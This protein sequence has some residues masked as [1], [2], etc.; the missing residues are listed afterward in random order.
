MRSGIFKKKKQV[1]TWLFTKPDSSWRISKASRI[2]VINKSNVWQQSVAV[3]P[4]ERWTLADSYSFF[5]FFIVLDKM[6]RWQ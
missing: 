6:R 4:P 3:L 5:L 2:Q 1:C